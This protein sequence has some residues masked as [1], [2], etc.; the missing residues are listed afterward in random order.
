MSEKLKFMQDAQPTALTEDFYYM[1]GLGGWCKPENFLEEEDAEKVR[2]A[3][4][5]I[6]QYE[7]QGIEEG[8]FEEI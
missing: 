2:A 1:I 3:I 4:E 8:F 5:I 7:Q 6:K